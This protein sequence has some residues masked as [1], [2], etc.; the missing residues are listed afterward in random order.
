MFV[1]SRESLRLL[2][3]LKHLEDEDT[4]DDLG[5]R[6]DEIGKFAK[7]EVDIDFLMEKVDMVIV[8]GYYN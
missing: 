3:M 5:V 6:P 4:A 8:S 1:P 2:N 7:F